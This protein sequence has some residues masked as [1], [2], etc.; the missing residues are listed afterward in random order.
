MDSVGVLNQNRG[1]VYPAAG[2][3]VLDSK[4]LTA[5]ATLTTDDS[6]EVLADS[7]AGVMTVTLPVAPY[8]GLEIRITLSSASVNA[9]TVDGNG[10]NVNGAASYVMNTPRMSRTFRYNGTEYNIVGGY[11]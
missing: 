8:E 3:E 11:L 5:S 4:D 2:Y 9:V 6:R 1:R 7:T 10:K